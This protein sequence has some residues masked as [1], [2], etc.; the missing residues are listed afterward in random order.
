MHICSITYIPQNML[1]RYTLKQSKHSRDQRSTRKDKRTF[2]KRLLIGGQRQFLLSCSSLDNPND[3]YDNHDYLQNNFYNDAAEQTHD[4]TEGY[5]Y[6]FR[7]GF[8]SN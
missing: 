7:E 5:L 2:Y 1:K 6:R 4:R 8:S 3:E